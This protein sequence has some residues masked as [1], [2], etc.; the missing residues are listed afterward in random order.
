MGERVRRL[1]LDWV[2]PPPSIE[3]QSMW[4]CLH[5]GELQSVHADTL[6]R[7]LELAFEVSYLQEHHRL[8]DDLLFQFRFSGVRSVRA[9]T[10]IRWPG[11]FPNTEG[12]PREEE[13]QLIREYW[14]K[15]REESVTWS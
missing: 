4:N 2:H 6:E 13:S 15:G 14:S 5:D 9:T 10:F 11:P 12:K 1:E 3:P 8:P 7:S